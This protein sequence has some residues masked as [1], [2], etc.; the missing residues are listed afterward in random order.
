MLRVYVTCFID[1]NNTNLALTHTTLG[2]NL[3]LHFMIF[4]YINKNFIFN[5]FE[6]ICVFISVLL[7]SFRY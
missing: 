5:Y 1:K 4:L 6:F 2:V 3:V 7:T